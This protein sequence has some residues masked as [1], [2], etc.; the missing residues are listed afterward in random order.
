MSSYSTR[1]AYLDSRK[2][3]IE[4]RP[5]VWANLRAM[6]VARQTRRLLAM[7]DDR[8]LADIGIGRGDASTESARPMWDIETLR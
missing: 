3:Q 8:T 5:S 6:I 7:M 1:I 2:A 4:V